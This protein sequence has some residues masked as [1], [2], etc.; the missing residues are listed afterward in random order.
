MWKCIMEDHRHNNLR[1][2]LVSFG[3]LT[4]AQFIRAIKTVLYPITLRVYFTN[5]LSIGTLVGGHRAAF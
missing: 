4:T 5:A 2:N 3:V 1:L